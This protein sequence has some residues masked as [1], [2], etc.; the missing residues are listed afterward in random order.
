MPYLFRGI[1]TNF[2]G[3][4][5]FRA[6]GSYLTTEWITCIIPIIPIRS[7]RILYWYQPPSFWEFPKCVV[8]EIGRPCWKQVAS[9]YAFLLFLL[10]LPIV[11]LALLERASTVRGATI[12]VV[13]LAI[14]CLIPAVVPK[15][16]RRRARRRLLP[17]PSPPPNSPCETISS[18]HIP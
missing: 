4:R 1:G 6:D 8:T 12:S 10:P 2:C 3:Q 13:L 9:V 15:L 11:P 18:I 17:C 5:D 16:L 14:A 7:L